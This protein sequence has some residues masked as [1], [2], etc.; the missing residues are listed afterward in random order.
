MA[1]AIVQVVVENGSV[2]V[3]IVEKSGHLRAY[4]GVDGKK[5]AEDHHVVGVHFGIHKIELIM[6]MIFVEQVFSV[7]LLVEESQREG[8][9]GVGKHAHAAVIYTIVAQEAL[10]PFAHTVVAGLTDKISGHTSAPQRYDGIECRAA[11]NGLERLFALENN[12]EH[13]LANTYY[14]SHYQSY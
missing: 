2:L 8:R 3:G 7:V 9:L 4:Y 5:R 6:G 13:S 1:G 10:H 11:R 14:T 12:V